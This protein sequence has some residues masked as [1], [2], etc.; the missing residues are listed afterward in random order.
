MQYRKMGRTG[1]MVSKI[2]LGTMTFGQQ[3]NEAAA[4]IL[5]TP[6]TGMS[7]ESPKKSPARR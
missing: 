5:L 4:S 1:L 7:M 6:R 2:C 3:V